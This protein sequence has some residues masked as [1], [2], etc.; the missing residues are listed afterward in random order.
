SQLPPAYASSLQQSFQL[1]ESLYS[2]G[3]YLAALAASLDV[4]AYAENLLAAPGADS[5]IGVVRQTAL[6]N[7]Y[8][9]AACGSSD[10]LPLSYIQFGD[11]YAGRD[12][13]TALYMYEVASMYAA[14]IGDIICA[15]G[16]SYKVIPAPMPSIGGAPTPATV[17]TTSTMAYAGGIA[18][19]I[20]PI[21]I[22]AFI[23]A[24]MAIALKRR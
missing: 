4:I 18:N 20:A 1:A 2:G 9:S 12:N 22:L 6:Q 24:V 11:Y 10:I 14:A 19:Y 16:A 13:M 21:A 23:I 7:I 5:L 8:R 3:H 15:P 17:P